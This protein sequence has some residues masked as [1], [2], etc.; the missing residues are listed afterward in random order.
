MFSTKSLGVDDTRT[1]GRNSSMLATVVETIGTPSDAYT[2]SFSGF[3]DWVRGV[4]AWGTIATSNA[5]MYLR[6][7]W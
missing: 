1:R 3:I 6:A 4:S 5:A 2:K 7:S